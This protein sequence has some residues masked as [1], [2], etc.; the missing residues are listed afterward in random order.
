MTSPPTAAK[1]PG[2]CAVFGSL[3]EALAGGDF[4]AVDLMLLH[5]DHEVSYDLQPVHLPVHHCGVWEVRV[6]TVVLLH[7]DHEAT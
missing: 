5:T 2:G 3:G 7:T 6:I 4:D 1:V